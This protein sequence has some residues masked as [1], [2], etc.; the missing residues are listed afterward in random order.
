[1]T[2][3]TRVGTMA[4]RRLF[5]TPAFTSAC[6]LSLGLG[7]GACVPILSIARALWVQSSIHE[8][9]SVIRLFRTVATD[10]SGAARVSEVF[11]WAAYRALQ[12]E[13]GP[14]VALGAELESTGVMGDFRPQLVLEGRP[15]A[16]IAVSSTY[17]DVLGVAVRGPGLGKGDDEPGS[18]PA[19]ILSDAIW[20]TSSS[21]TGVPLSEHV[22]I[23]GTPVRVAGVAAPRFN[24]VHRGEHVDAWIPVGT[25]P[26]FSPVTGNDL[27]FSLLR[28]YGRMR[29]GAG[30]AEVDVHV[31]RTLG[32][33]VFVRAVA[34]TTY[35]REFASRAHRDGRVL[36]FLGVASAIVLVLGCTNVVSLLLARGHVRQ[37]E[38][39]IR[40]SIGCSRGHLVA[41]F[42]AEA[43]WL[44]ALGTIAGLLLGRVVLWALQHQALPSSL[45]IGDL[46]GMDAVSVG[47]AVTA[48]ALTAAIGTVVSALL[49]FRTSPAPLDQH[50]GSTFGG[51]LNIRGFL[52]GFHIAL[53]VVL[54]VGALLVG[55]SLRR[56]LAVDLGFDVDRTLQVGVTPSVSG[57]RAVAGDGGFP[58]R[59]REDYVRLM[60]S[61][62]QIPGVVA[63]AIGMLPL[64]AHVDGQ[65]MMQAPTR[66]LNVAGQIVA[67]PVAV[68]SGGAG[69]ASALGLG[70][71]EGRDFQDADLR[72]GERAAI[73][74]VAAARSLFGN[75]SPIGH[76]VTLPGATQ[77]SRIVGVVRD[78]AHVSLRSHRPA[79]VY[80]IDDLP[81]DESQ[82]G[83]TFIVRTAGSPERFKPEI[84]R[85]VLS[86]FP[87][88][89]SWDVTTG[90]EALSAQLRDQAFGA[91]VSACY[92]AIALLLALIGVHTSVAVMI[93]SRRRELAIR[94]AVGAT[95]GRVVRFVC[96]RAL[97]PVLLGVVIGIGGSLLAVRG[98]NALLLEV[99]PFHWPSYLAVALAVTALAG[100]QAVIAARHLLKLDP[101]HTLRTAAE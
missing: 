36:G 9:T 42:G 12:A 83:L 7:I 23:S 52:L 76:A 2:L 14:L 68:T 22:A 24:G 28:V 89:T 59:R 3:W 61:L 41:L 40:R 82:P 38:T 91:S 84:A 79:T 70:L 100:L 32:S 4:C 30:I 80:V 88:V 5:R 87:H 64:A 10:S 18:A 54:F 6:A 62:K 27:K 72:A 15:L 37:R 1:M 75:Q 16:A 95:A 19:V 29:P 73:L 56:G 96:G 49:A 31:K 21:R 74:N 47:V 63:V 67:L 78:S 25:L 8:P 94:L 65:A 33:A 86:S 51:R 35:G 11:P 101:A 71:S 17:F 60:G 57:Y 45:Q 13:P 92:G 99:S 69:F 50:V 81:S 77:A 66:S 58:Q 34:E 48:G 98:L 43:L 44:A 46:P 55:E 85:I 90:R 97:M 26:R 53:T 39:A 93:A 20:R